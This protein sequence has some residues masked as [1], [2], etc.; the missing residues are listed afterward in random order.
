MKIRYAAITAALLVAL[1]GCASTPEQ[2]TSDSEVSEESVAGETIEAAPLTVT[3]PPAPEIDPAEEMQSKWY[4][5]FGKTL[6]SFGYEFPLI[7]DSLPVGQYIC[8]QS[9]A[10]VAPEDIAAVQGLPE[11]HQDANTQVVNFTLNNDVALTDA[12]IA[13]GETLPD[14]CGVLFPAS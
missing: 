7:G 13:A 11:A 4:G 10:E 5:R 8:D 3:Q 6:Q 1:T 12:A 9:R 2:V 14:Y